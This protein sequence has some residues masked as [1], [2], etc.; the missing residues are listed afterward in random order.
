[1]RKG[2]NRIDDLSK[3]RLKNGRSKLKCELKKKYKIKA[4]GFNTVI[5]ELKQRMS[6]KTLKLKRYKSRGK[7]YR[8]K[9][10]LRKTEKLYMK[11]QI[12][13]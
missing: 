7:Q 12:D 3:G 2:L 10:L 9:E 8:Q 5:E 11:S 13:K 1:M 4:K 6:A